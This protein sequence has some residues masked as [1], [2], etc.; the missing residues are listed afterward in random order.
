M[1]KIPGGKIITKQPNYIHIEYTS[2][3]FK[4]V[5]D[6]EFYFP[7]NQKIIHMKSSSRTGHYD[8]GVNRKRLEKIRF[9]F[10]QGV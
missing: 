7:D 1:A 2:D 3:L 10:I 5:D 8:F 4:F 6:V 9:E